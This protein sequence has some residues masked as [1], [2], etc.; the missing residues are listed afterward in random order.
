MALRSKMLD[1]AT[2]LP[3]ETNV[4]MYDSPYEQQY[5]KSFQQALG[6]LQQ[7]QLQPGQRATSGAEGQ[8][9]QGLEQ[10]QQLAQAQASRRG[11]DPSAARAAGQAGGEMM[12]QGYGM[13][14][15]LRAQEEAARRQQMLDLYRQRSQYDVQG[16]GMA[17]ERLQEQLGQQAFDAA[18]KAQLDAA[19]RQEEAAIGQGIL[20]AVGDVGSAFIGSDVRMKRNIKPAGRELDAAMGMLGDS[21]KKR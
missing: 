17:S 11:F 2:G 15:Q 14:Q 13:A 12:S 1:P 10:Q 4:G 16:A 20:K 19:A 3:M 8:M 18:V 21:Y 5:G 6:M 7:P 9:W